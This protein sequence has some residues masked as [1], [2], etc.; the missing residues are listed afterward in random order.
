MCEGA[1]RRPPP[2]S[3]TRSGLGALLDEIH[4]LEDGGVAAAVQLGLVH[5]R[6]GGQVRRRARTALVAFV[7]PAAVVAAVPAAGAAVVAVALMDAGLL[8][9]AAPDL[10]ALVDATGQRRV[11][12]QRDRQHPGA[13]PW[14]VLGEAGDGPDRLLAVVHAVVVGVAV[15]RVRVLLHLLGVVDAVVVLIVVRVA[16]AVVVAVGVARARA[17]A[18]LAQVVEPVA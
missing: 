6:A 11:V 1:A 14:R 10:G 3:T 17:R 9:R 16:Y 2:L 8:G 5:G 7:A 13:G 12:L 18:E 15:T 4:L